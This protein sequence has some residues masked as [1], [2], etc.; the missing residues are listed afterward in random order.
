LSGGERETRKE[1]RK[2]VNEKKREVRRTTTEKELREQRDEAMPG[3][4][5]SNTRRSENRV[6]ESRG[7]SGIDWKRERRVTYKKLEE[8]RRGKGTSL[9]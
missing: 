5:K 1:L 7:I 9:P 6:G 3:G 8:I 2:T 4:P